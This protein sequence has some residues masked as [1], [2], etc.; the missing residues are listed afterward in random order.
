MPS[1]RSL[2]HVD[3]LEEIHH[4]SVA[5]LRT[6]LAAYIADGTRP[7]PAARAGGAF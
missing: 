2:A 4:A 7:D 6:A 5:A 3:A 1:A